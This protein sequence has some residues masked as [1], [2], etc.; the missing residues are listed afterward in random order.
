MTALHSLRPAVGGLIRNPILL[1]IT[2]VFALI[3]IPQLILQSQSPLIS[4]VVSLL[5]TGVLLIVLPFYQGGVIGMSNEALTGTARVSSMIEAGKSNYVALLLSYLAILAVN[6]VFGVAVA[7]VAVG[8]GLGFL[9]GD[10]QPNLAVLAVVGLLGLGLLLVYFL[11]V[12]S[13]QFYAHAIVLNNTDVIEG[14]K[15]SVRLVRENKLSVTGYTIIMFLG[16]AVLG[17]GSGAASLVFSPELGVGSA[18]PE[19]SLPFVI[20][21]LVLYIGIAA[22]FGAFYGMYSVSFYQNVSVDHPS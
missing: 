4:T 15:R 9:V 19:F 14:F 2:G 18:L 16:G 22:V 12:I 11:F 7:L 3:Q 20:F 6:I 8:G 21:G 5:M 10:G 1:V 17:L 13:I